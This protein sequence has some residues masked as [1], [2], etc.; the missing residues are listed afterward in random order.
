MIWFNFQIKWEVY[1]SK[2]HCPLV[3]IE[4]N[5]FL[6]AYVYE[7]ATQLYGLKW[8]LDYYFLHTIIF[9]QITAVFESV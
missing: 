3:V 5:M 8:L 9:F 2:E 6:H 1:F 4:L 7:Y